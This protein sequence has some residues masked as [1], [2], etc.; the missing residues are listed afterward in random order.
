MSGS[1][2]SVGLIITAGEG[3]ERALG[4]QIAY[5][6]AAG[7]SKIV[8][9]SSVELAV[10]AD[11][12]TAE[13]D[14][15]ERFLADCRWVISIAA[16]EFLFAPAG[17]NGN[18]IRGALA[19][20][21]G[22]QRAPLRRYQLLA[23]TVDEF[24]QPQ[25]QTLRMVDCTAV[26]EYA[27]RQRLGDAEAAER[28]LIALSL[29]DRVSAHGE[30]V[31]GTVIADYRVQKALE[32]LQDGWQAAAFE[33][34]QEVEISLV[35]VADGESGELW[36]CL[37]SI[38]A[39]TR[40]QF[41]TI[42]VIIGEQPDTISTV[43][44]FRRLYDE[45]PLEIVRVEGLSTVA[46]AKNAG[47]AACRGEY[48]LTMLAADKLPPTYLLELMLA[49][50]GPGSAFAYG[51]QQDFGG[52]ARF[53]AR[54]EF[55]AAALTRSNYVGPTALF[56]KSAWEAVGGYDE[57]LE[58]YESWDFWLA[59]LAAGY[60]GA[61]NVNATFMRRVDSKLIEGERRQDSL[62]K[63]QIVLN[64]PKLYSFSELE[65]AAAVLA[66]DEEML[67]LDQ[68]LWSI[69]A[70]PPTASENEQESKATT[71]I[72][73][74]DEKL[75]NRVNVWLERFDNSLPLT[76]VVIGG[77]TAEGELVPALAAQQQALMSERAP[78]VIVIPEID[79]RFAGPTV[80]GADALLSDRERNDSLRGLPVLGAADLD[81]LAAYVESKRDGRPAILPRPFA[82]RRSKSDYCPK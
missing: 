34:Q 30:L 7:I 66:G 16:G 6:R 62:L 76:L 80:T 27:C 18:T 74:A 11:L 79:P 29:A 70:L 53:H 51:S 14:R 60:S 19:S 41:E 61:Y 57:R 54:Q 69:P 15:A 20:L 59:L 56:R 24:T 26:D 23:M 72:T 22:A 55:S 36:E 58:A 25:K 35:V 81:Q 3:Q 67:A 64:H 65:W 48:V 33:E 63:A 43:A 4:K 17:V 12:V 28:G 50:R 8:V 68:E 75:A 82:A 10:A 46:A 42:V 77:V 73:F 1:G 39:Q 21:G 40:R 13:T 52:S 78:T 38:Q 45:I 5:H 9:I 31:P 71:V 32:R 44:E 37:E 49:Y 47:V 2:L